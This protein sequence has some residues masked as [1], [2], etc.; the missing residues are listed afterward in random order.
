MSDRSLPRKSSAA[1]PLRERR[2]RRAARAGSLPWLKGLLARPLQLRRADGALRPMLVDRRRSAAQIEADTR[3]QLCEGLKS[4]LIAHGLAQPRGVMR[5][6]IRVRSRLAEAGWSGVAALPSAVLGPAVVQLQMLRSIEPAAAWAEMADR[7]RVLK[8]AA[9]VREDAA[10]HVHEPAGSAL[11][12][13]VSECP[14]EH[15][16]EAERSWGG[17]APPLPGDRDHGR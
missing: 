2:A 16:E 6:L 11:A 4:L 15:F 14:H 3:R 13:D 9:E 17:V 1:A 8:A 5:D 7:L 10:P 12:V